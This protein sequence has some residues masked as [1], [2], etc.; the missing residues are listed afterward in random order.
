MC[1]NRSVSIVPGLDRVDQLVLGLL[2]SSLRKLSCPLVLAVAQ[3]RRLALDSDVLVERN[4]FA[5][6][7]EVRRRMRAES[8]IRATGPVADH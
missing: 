5:D 1:R 8:E 7:A 2:R 3:A 4:R 6:G